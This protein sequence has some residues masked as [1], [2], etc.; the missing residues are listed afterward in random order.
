MAFPT[1]KSNLVDNV[2]DV[3]ADHINNIE[4][5]VGIDG[6]TETTSLDYILK[7]GWI[8]IGTL[9]R[10]SDTTATL[11]GNWTDR[12]QKGDK[13]RWLSDGSLRQNYVIGV[14]YSSP[15]TTITITGGY[16]TIAN[17]SRFEEGKT[18]TVP[19]ISKIENPQGFPGFFKWT[20]TYGGSGSMTYTDVI[21]Y[22]IGFRIQGKAVTFYLNC[23]GTTGETANN[24]LTFSAPVAAVKVANTFGGGC[25]VYDGGFKSGFFYIATGPVFR[26]F[27]YDGSNY[28]LGTN[29]QI[30]VFDTYEMA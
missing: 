3:M 17:D 16:Q 11:S 9:T 26:V 7:K 21:T 5:K 10:T 22:D 4:D 15:N 28:A 6:D 30:V 12:I 1:S 8:N 23:G 19:Q 27:K 18:I 14:S 25:V 20:P 24:Y 29:K 2:D 13:L